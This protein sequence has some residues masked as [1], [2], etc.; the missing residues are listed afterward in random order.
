MMAFFVYVLPTVTASFFQAI[1]KPI[2]ALAI[3][4]SRQIL[5]LIPLAILFSS[6]YG[7]DGALLSA[8]LA[9]VLAF[10]FAMVLIIYEWR[11]WKEKGFL[12]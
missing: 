12:L 2:N 10:V 8:P 1:G 6:Q 4:I 5:F 7:L 11:K 9:D 3:S